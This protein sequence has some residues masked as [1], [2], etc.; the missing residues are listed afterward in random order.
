MLLQ[1]QKTFWNDHGFLVL[2]RFYTPEEVNR[3]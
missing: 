1:E 2:P 3:V